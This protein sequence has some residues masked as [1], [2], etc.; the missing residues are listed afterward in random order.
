MRDTTFFEQVTQVETPWRDQTIRLPI[1]YYD[2]TT[3]AAAFLTPLAPVRALLP[4]P[5]LQPLRATPWHTVT[6]ITAFEY[7]DSD[8]GPYNE[9]AI[10]FPITLDRPAPILTGLLRAMAAG[11][12]AYVH[13]LPVTTEI[14]YHAGVDFYNYPKFV[15]QITFRREG[16]WLHCH[17]AEGERTILTLTVRQLPTRPLDR[18]R[19]H[20]IT[21]REERILRSE[22]I[23]NVHRQAISR[24]PAH[25]RLELG[26]HPIAHELRDLRLGRAVHV[27]YIPQ[28]QAILT[29][30]LESY[31][32]R[33]G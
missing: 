4:S 13:H 10:A 23:V 32:A 1:F 19:F 18:W 3:V 28:N 30:V 31:A 8:I 9:V 6:I 33:K 17:L 16:E 15:A 7:R 24:N 22:V 14:A 5:R 25:V 20:G 2:V 21:F 12:L 11:P 27:Q 29:P 26:D